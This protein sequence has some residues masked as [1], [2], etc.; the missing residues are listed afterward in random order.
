V[1]PVCLC[2]PVVRVGQGPSAAE[3]GPGSAGSLVPDH[4]A[5][6][7]YS[8]VAEVDG[9]AV[10][11]VDEVVAAVAGD[12]GEVVRGI[13]QAPSAAEPET[14]SARSLGPDGTDSTV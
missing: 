9:A 8:G 1:S 7:V 6:G 11:P 4:G 5:V 10:D 3:P 2:E 12:V 14:G 13:G